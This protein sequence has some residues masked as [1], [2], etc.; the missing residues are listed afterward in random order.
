MNIQNFQ[1]TFPSDNC[2]V[3]K[4][5]PPPVFPWKNHPISSTDDDEDDWDPV[6]K[7]LSQKTTGGR[8]VMDQCRGEIRRV[9]YKNNKEWDD[10]SDAQK[11]QIPAVATKVQARAKVPLEAVFSQHVRRSW[12]KPALSHRS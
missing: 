5:S 9:K 2:S 6:C 11:H 3:M 4:E 12:Q 10:A 7:N 1:L 8:R